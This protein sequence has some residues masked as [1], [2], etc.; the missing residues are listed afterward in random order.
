[1]VFLGFLFCG[2]CVKLQYL[3]TSIAVTFWDCLFLS[4]PFLLSSSLSLSPSINTFSHYTLSFY[5]LSRSTLFLSPVLLSFIA[6]TFYLILLSTVS[7][8][9]YQL[10]LPLFLHSFRSLS[11]SYLAVSLLWLTLSTS[12]Q[13]FL[14]LFTL[15]LN[16]FLS[17][18]LSMF[19]HFSSLTWSHFQIFIFLL[20]LQEIL[21]VSI[22]DN[23]WRLKLNNFIDF[24]F[25]CSFLFGS[26]HFQRLSFFHQHE[27]RIK[28]KN[29]FFIRQ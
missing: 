1:M 28:V 12:F 3:C 14:T 10:F 17:L 8:S 15:F 21:K 22:F 27:L 23:F 4:L 11:P 18:S 9:L 16:N 2:L 7:Y 24:S 29:L 20:R 19:Y 5:S 13:L 25:L 6:L 26:K